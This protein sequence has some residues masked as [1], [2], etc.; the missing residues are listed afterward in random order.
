[1]WNKIRCIHITRKRARTR[2]KQ[3]QLRKDAEWEDK[4][5]KRKIKDLPLITISLVLINVI[6]LILSFLSV[7][8]QAFLFEFGFIPSRLGQLSSLP[9]LISHMFLHADFFH[10]FYNML[11]FLQF[12][13][14]AELKLGRIRFI[15]LYLLSGIFAVLFYA[16]LNLESEIPLVGASGAIFGTLASYAL[17]YPKKPLYFLRRIKVPSIVGVSFVFILEI[18]YAF[19]GLNPYIANTAHLGGGIAGISLTAI[20]FPKETINTFWNLLDAI[21]RALIPP[22]PSRKPE[23]DT[24][25]EATFSD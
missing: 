19:I 18:I 10:I 6:I 4:G 7:D 12:G 17:L 14:L 16:L 23:S 21:T 20:F 9:S 3:K 22:S 25:V 2:E 8:F 15:L 5:H 13:S 11:L 24:S 1:M